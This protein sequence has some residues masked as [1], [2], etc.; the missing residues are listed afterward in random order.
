MSWENISWPLRRRR[1]E[2]RSRQGAAIGGGRAGK[3]MG[4]YLGSL[5]GDRLGTCG[6]ATSAG[7]LL[8]AIWARDRSRGSIGRGGGAHL[9][10]P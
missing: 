3:A 1:I 5:H 8:A 2:E 6:R 9:A 7:P 4:V 10:K